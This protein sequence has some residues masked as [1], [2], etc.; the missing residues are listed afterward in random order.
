M[1]YPVL[2]AFR[3]R[4]LL[5]L[6]TQMLC[7]G[8]SDDAVSTCSSGSFSACKA[9]G[10]GSALAAAYHRQ[11]TGIW[12]IHR[13]TTDLLISCVPSSTLWITLLVTFRASAKLKRL[14]AMLSVWGVLMSASY[15]G[16]LLGIVM[17]TLW[18]IIFLSTWLPDYHPA[19]L[20]FS[21][22]NIWDEIVDCCNTN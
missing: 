12:C 9:S 5:L 15:N 8:F 18:L 14:R 19:V 13:W 1:L 16:A 7:L 11:V 21:G 22:L 6:W 20:W 10:S 3:E 2:F 17:N 4:R